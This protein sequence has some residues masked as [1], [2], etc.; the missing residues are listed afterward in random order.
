MDYR[1]PEWVAEKLGIEK[2]TVYKY[3]QDGTLPAIQLGRKWLI[4]E[5][6]LEKWLSAETQRQT[7]ARRDAA[8]SVDRTIQRM[9]NFS[10]DT[11][12][13]IRLA[14]G[15][16]RRMGHSYLGQEHLVLGLA[17][18]EQSQA[19]RALA[20]LGL[21]AEKLREEV[22]ARVR[23]GDSVPPR[24]LARSAEAKKAMRLAARQAGGGGAD[25]VQSE[26]LLL[27]ILQSQEGVGYEMLTQL[28]VTEE[29]V[30]RQLA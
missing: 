18:V 25:P 27:G 30:R 12:E 7:K 24:R 22:A 9:D 17:G 16:A 6:E 21:T 8:L 3:L 1:D 26:H 15:E 28:G 4:S 11:Q 29:S 20:G 23:P 5:A 13:A 19:A 10:P 14:H 2:N